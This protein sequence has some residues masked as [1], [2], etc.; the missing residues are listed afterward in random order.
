VHF[1]QSVLGFNGQGVRIGILDDGVDWKHSSNWGRCTA[2]AT[3]S[4]TC[5]VVA[6]YNPFLETGDT[7]RGAHMC[8]IGGHLLGAALEACLVL[9]TAGSGTCSCSD[10][11]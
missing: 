11:Q 10:V 8:S 6:S 1:A 9:A 2:L 5:R 7:V 4:S 3:P